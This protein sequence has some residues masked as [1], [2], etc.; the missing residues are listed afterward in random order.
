MEHSARIAGMRTGGAQGADRGARAPR[1]EQLL[2]LATLPHGRQVS[3]LRLAHI[4][5]DALRLLLRLLLLL[6][7]ILAGLQ[8][9]SMLE[10]ISRIL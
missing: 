4:R 10:C 7:R 3:R 2:P 9:Q 5:R 1:Q 8:L 6:L